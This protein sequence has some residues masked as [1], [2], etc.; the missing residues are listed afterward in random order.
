[1]YS[2]SNINAPAE[3]DKQEGDGVMSNGAIYGAI[4]LSDLHCEH[5]CLHVRAAQRIVH[6][7]HS[8]TVFVNSARI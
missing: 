7:P 4:Q 3:V 8:Q 6:I 2:R 1:M 5:P